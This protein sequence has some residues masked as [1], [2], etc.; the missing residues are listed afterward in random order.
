MNYTNELNLPEPFVDAVKSNHAYKEHR[1]SVT[2]VLGGTC[3]AILKRRHD[4]EITEDVSQRIWAL[5]GTAV[6]K[7]LQEAEASPDQIQENWL[8]VEIDG[9]CP[10]YELSGIFDLYDDSTGTVTDYKTCS[11]WKLQVGDFEDWRM[12]TLMYCWLLRRAGFDA[13]NGEV[14]AIMRDHNMR[15]AKTEKDYPKHP[16]MRIEWHFTDEDMRAIEEH[17]YDWFHAVHE[18]GYRTDEELWPCSPDQRWHKPD[19]WAVVKDGNKRAT[20]VFENEDDAEFSRI[21]L[22]DTTGKK[23]HIEFRQG[24]DTRCQSYCSVAE[25][26][27]YGRKNFENGENS[28]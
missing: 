21:L 7:V 27:P 28:R 18:Q 1:Y 2:E 23:H 6:H 11:V 25:F 10:K 17:I 20:R 24:E 15:K 16:V 19:K 26:C 22:E 14:V 5:F 8:C 12:Q 9:L 4:G 3:E 13:R